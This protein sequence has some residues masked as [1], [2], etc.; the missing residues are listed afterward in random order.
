MV[1]FKAGILAPEDAYFP[2]R[3]RVRSYQ[4]REE[5]GDEVRVSWKPQEKQRE[6]SDRDHCLVM[7]RVRGGSSVSV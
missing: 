4:S 6:R 2:N 3:Q 5:E 1:Q 7:G